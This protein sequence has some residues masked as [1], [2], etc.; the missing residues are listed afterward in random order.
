MENELKSSI[1][2]ALNDITDVDLLDLIY[3]ILI[4]SSRELCGGVDPLVF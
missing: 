2:E 1:I 4:E 3:K